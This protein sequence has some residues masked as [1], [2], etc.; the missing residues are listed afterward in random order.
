VTIVRLVLVPAVMTLMGD[1]NWWIP[2]WLDRRLPTIDISGEAG[3]PA[4]E[5]QAGPEVVVEAERAL[6]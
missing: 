1:A 3:L 2:G 6:V 4:A 5:M